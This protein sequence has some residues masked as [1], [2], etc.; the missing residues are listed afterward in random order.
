MQ[1]RPDDALG[2][3]LAGVAAEPPEQSVQDE[4]RAAAPQGQEDPPDDLG[5]PVTPDHSQSAPE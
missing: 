1:P 5:G 4:L 3:D 2:P